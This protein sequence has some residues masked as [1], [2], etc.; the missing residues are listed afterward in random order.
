M[1]A[2]KENQPTPTFKPSISK[3][4]SKLKGR[5]W[6]EL[7][8][9]DA[10]RREALQEA[11]RQKALQKEFEETTFQPSISKMH[12]VSGKLRILDD[13][14]N[15]L[16]RVEVVILCSLFDN[17]MDKLSRELRT[18]TEWSEKRNKE[19]QECSF[20]PEVHD[21]PDYIKRI[22]RTIKSVKKPK[23]IPKR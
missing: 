8:I 3:T 20:R 7:S 10:M 14:D 2:S 9:G 17:K 16:K 13:A 15:Y 19:M 4:A 5:S 11:E 18:E 22:A 23:V 12:G 21:A 6:A 1:Q